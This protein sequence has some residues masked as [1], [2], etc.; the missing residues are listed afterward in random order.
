[1]ENVLMSYEH[2]GKEKENGWDFNKWSVTLEYQGREITVEFSTGMVIPEPTVDDVLYS[3]LIDSIAEEFGS[4]EDW[5]VSVGYDTDSRKAEKIYNA[6]LKN[7]EL[8]NN[9][10]GDDIEYFREK[11]ENY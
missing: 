5:A 10:L 3:L 2:I 8:L 9:L 7:A 11:Y 6:C 4:F 1:M